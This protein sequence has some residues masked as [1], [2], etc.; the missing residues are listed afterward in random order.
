MEEAVRARNVGKRAA[1]SSVGMNGLGAVDA[2]TSALMMC[3]GGGPCADSYADRERRSREMTAADK[4]SPKTVVAGEG[5]D[6]VWTKRG[7]G[8]ACDSSG[9][10][11]RVMSCPLPAPGRTSR[12]AACIQLTLS[13]YIPL[14]YDRWAGGRTIRDSYCPDVCI[15]ARYDNRIMHGRDH[16]NLNMRHRQHEGKTNLSLP[17]RQT[18]EPVAPQIL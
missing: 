10:G 15:H 3:K 14:G 18:A 13:M 11:S 16:G 6:G 7:K 17:M 12:T 8:Q 9:V 1:E 2:T 4:G 5:E